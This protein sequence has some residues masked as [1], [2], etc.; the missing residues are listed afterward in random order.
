MKL[1]IVGSRAYKNEK[2]VRV[3][4]E[5]YNG[6]YGAGNVEIISGGCPDG[7]DAIAKKIAIE[8]GLKYVEFPP[9]HSKYNF[10]CVNPPDQY[11]KPYHVSNFFTRNSQIA[12][13]C[14][15]LA[16]FVVCGVKANGTMDTFNKATKLKKRC[17]LFEDKEKVI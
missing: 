8:M 9:I 6:F 4:L 12:E 3:L 1:A 5:K 7:G 11:N 17:F 2:K 10:Y 14:D 15:H 16:A 13:Y